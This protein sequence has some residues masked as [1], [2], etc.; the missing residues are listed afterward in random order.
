MEEKEAEER[1]PVENEL[2]VTKIAEMD[3]RP[4]RQYRKRDPLADY[5][6][7]PVPKSS[8]AENQADGPSDKPK[9]RRDPLAD[10]NKPPVPK[11]SAAENQADGPSDKPK[12]RRNPLADY[13]KPP[14]L[15]SSVAE[16]KRTRPNPLAK[17]KP[18]T[19]GEKNHQAGNSN[20]PACSKKTTTTTTTTV[21][22]K[23]RVGKPNAAGAKSKQTEALNNTP[24]TSCQ[25]TEHT[26]QSPSCGGETT[27][28]CFF[29]S[30]TKDVKERYPGRLNT[31]TQCH[32]YYMAQVARR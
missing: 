10:Y 26:Y 22:E 6:K 28:L 23:G 32:A 8:A 29:C 5:N 21:G 11:S 30:K 7:P 13:N 4:R 9:K 18:T 12:K 2:A 1:G 20:G 19:A 14:V 27:F 25:S 15:K 16:I 3:C 17:P 24:T 31:C